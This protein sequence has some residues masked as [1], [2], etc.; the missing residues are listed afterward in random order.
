MHW[1]RGWS[2]TDHV[3]DHALIT[4][5]IMHWSRGYHALI[6]WL[7]IHGSCAWSCTD[8]MTDHALNTWLIMH[9]S[10]GYHALLTWL[11]MQWSCSYDVP[12]RWLIIHPLGD[13]PCTDHVADHTLISCLVMHRSRDK[14]W[15]YH[16]AIMKWSPGWKCTDHVA[17]H[18]VIPW[19]SMN[20]S[21]DYHVVITWLNGSDHVTDHALIMFAIIHWSFASGGNK[22]RAQ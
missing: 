16:I 20:W 8:Y 9:W 15:T 14:S 18:A 21:H 4:W 10:R 17:D 5:L 3:T 13:G 2:C 11:I 12:V 19:L 6:T 1:S 22:Q 7:V